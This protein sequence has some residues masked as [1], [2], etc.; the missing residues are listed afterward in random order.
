MIVSINL[1]H[2]SGYWVQAPRPII[3]EKVELSV[4]SNST[5]SSMEKEIKLRLNGSHLFSLQIR[6]KPDVELKYWDIS[7]KVPE[8]NEYY[9]Q[10]AYFVMVTHGLEADP[11]D[12]T[13]RF[14][15]S[16]VEIISVMYIC[17]IISFF[18]YL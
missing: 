2:C 17:I 12:V 5:R 15:V 7:D 3:R 10:K 14:E 4:L 16:S 18:Q 11:M 13:L 8:P 1:Y 9:G 6:P